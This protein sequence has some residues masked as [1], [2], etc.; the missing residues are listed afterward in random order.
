MRMLS[1]PGIML[2]ATLPLSAQVSVLTYHNNP[3]RTGENLQETTLAPASMGGFG[4]LFAQSGDGQVYAQPLYMP[5]VSIGGV[6]HN[7]VFVATE[8]DSVYAFDADSNTGT[9][10]APLWQAAFANPAKGVRAVTSGELN[11]INTA[12]LV[13]ITGTP[14]IDSSTGTL[15]V[16]AKTVET[17]A[18]VSNFYQRLHALDI[19]SGAE[20]LGGPF[21]IQTSVPGTCSP[22]FNGRV[23]FSPY[24]QFQRAGL[25]LSKG[26]VYVAFAS[27]CDGDP[28]TG[29]LMAFNSSTGKLLST[30]DDGPIQGPEPYCRSGIWQGGAAPAVDTSDVLYFATG[31]G[32]FNANTTGGNDFGD[33]TLKLMLG[34][35]GFSVLDYFTPYNQLSLDQGDLDL[36][37]GGVLLLPDQPGANPHLLVQVGKEG[38][39]Y[40]INRDNMGKY[41]STGDTQIVQ[42]LPNAIGG[43]WGMPAFF[44]GSVYFGGS[45]DSLKA[46]SLTNGLLSTSPTSQSTHV[47]AGYGPTPSVSANGHTNGI[48]W[49]VDSAGYPN[50]PAVLY[51]YDA[52]N[53]ANQLYSSGINPG[54]Q[55]GPAVKFTVPTIANGKVYAGTGNTVEVFGLL[56]NSP[57]FSLAANPTSLAA[58][59]GTTANFQI[60]VLAEPGFSFNGTV[61]LSA[62]GLGAGFTPTFNPGSVTG[63]NSST[64]GVAIAGT[65]ANGSY[66]FTVTGVSGAVTQ[67]VNLTLVVTTGSSIVFPG[68]PLTIPGHATMGAR[69]T[70]NGTL[71][72]LDTIQFTQTGEPCLQGGTA[73]PGY[74]VNGAGI[75]VVPG[76][77][78]VG[79]TSTFEATFG[80]TSGVWNF[81]ALLM[82][83]SGVSPIGTV[84]IF[85]ANAQ[86]GLGSSTPPTSLVLPA[87]SLGALGFSAFSVTNPTITFIVP[88]TNYSDNTGSFVL[89]QAGARARH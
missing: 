43:T 52:T 65:V 31:N 28:Y 1:R 60:S 56:P 69:F 74:C 18:G 3:Y 80:T 11:C 22:N 46:Y 23:A 45:V 58:L 12:P 25:V 81:G 67:S 54:D 34:A 41:K 17:T 40:L 66:P 20:K 26:I 30:F 83:V 44:N 86:N 27:Q 71:T 24:R 48:V 33:S 8:N 62:S 13:G 79:S 50:L 77:S 19:T 88:D 21:V 53:L 59:P 10:A 35:A 16:V 70:Y 51:A 15:Y 37:S 36:G 73:T 29:W 2:L 9:N 39:I 6:T 32:Y 72:Q 64:L 57:N 42:T 38:S 5:N 7:V 85:P 47:Y 55:M 78:P 87:T 14:V 84:Q 89:T 76:S 68:G 49:A 82:E 61:A 63:S 75:V 4:K